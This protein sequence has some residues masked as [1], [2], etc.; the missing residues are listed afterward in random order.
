MPA[1]SQ[2]TPPCGDDPLTDTDLEGW[3]ARVAA[4]FAE[5]AQDF[6]Q[7]LDP[8][9][10]D[11]ADGN[12]AHSVAWVAFPASLLRD[13]TSER[14]RWA[15]ADR[16]RRN[17]DEYGEWAVVRDGDAIHRVTFTTETPEY[18]EQLFKTNRDLLL[19]LYQEFTGQDVALE[20]ISNASGYVRGNEF[21]NTTAGSIIHLMQASNTLEAAVR[22][23]AEATVLRIAD[24]VPVTNQQ[25]LVIC[26]G[27]GDP[28]RN[29]DPQIAAA[30][31]QLAAAGDDVTLAD[32]PGLYIDSFLTA[33]M[34]TPDGTDAAEF[35]RVERSGEAG[36][37][38]A[39]F[40]V[41]PELG[42]SVSEITI[43]GRPIDFGAQLADRVQIKITAVSSP[44]SHTPEPEPCVGE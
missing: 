44:A 2:F 14:G 30:I 41:P 21:N 1:V 35:W 8:T 10:S 5:L 23:A 29:S 40:E 26:G 9:Q 4:I 28:F 31:N 12:R 32:P 7:F 27:L 22:L 11:L 37:V 17:Q 43:G 18:Y 15:E 20:D 3:S 36:A 34:R 42:Y 13:A 16:A 38:R 6:P 19:E 24:G 25:E 39:S 33:G